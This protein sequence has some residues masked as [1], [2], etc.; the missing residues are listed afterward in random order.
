MNNFSKNIL[1]TIE[2]EQI[3]PRPRWIFLVRQAALFIAFIF[4]I[5][6][7][8]VSVAVILFSVNDI[9]WDA[10]RMMNAHPGPFLLTYLPYVWVI[11]LVLFGLMAYYE[12]R[13]TKTG[14]RYRTATLLGASFLAS[15]VV[16]VFLHSVGAGQAIDRRF[17]V[18]MPQY[19]GLDARKASLWM[20]PGDGMLAGTII[21]G[22]ATSTFVMEDFMGVRWVVDAKD[23]IRHGVLGN[24]GSVRVRVIGS[25]AAPGI[26]RATELFPWARHA[27]MQDGLPQGFP[28][29]SEQGGMLF[30]QAQ[31]GLR[32]RKAPLLP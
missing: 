17:S 12:V 8:G 25:V 7:G 6:I 28:V 26:F 23:A 24:E 15:L 22:S 16:G 29:M 20:R 3:E 10:P 19:R 32:E 9:D 4:S 18:M 5:L 30:R 11:A 14:Y 2:Q 1:H 21:S 27:M 31:N 13:H